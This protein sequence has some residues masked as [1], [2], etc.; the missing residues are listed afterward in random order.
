MH[1][2]DHV[3]I[4]T[5]WGGSYTGRTGTIVEEVEISCDT[6]YRVKFDKPLIRDGYQCDSDIFLPQE[7]TVINK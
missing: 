7:L 2:K 6:W 3:K 4:T 1:V 5:S